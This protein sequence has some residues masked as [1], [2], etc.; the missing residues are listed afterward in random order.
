MESKHFPREALFLNNKTESAKSNSAAPSQM[1]ANAFFYILYMKL[2]L[3]VYMK[4]NL[5]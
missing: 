3:I 1:H 5:V 2:K 4:M